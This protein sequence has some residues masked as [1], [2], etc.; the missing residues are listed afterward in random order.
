[1][2]ADG[3]NDSLVNDVDSDL[4]R[5]HFGQF[6]SSASGSAGAPAI[7]EPATALLLLF[8]IAGRECIDSLPAPYREVLIL[9][10][11]VELDTD[12]I[13]AM[14]GVSNGVVKTRL[15]RARQAFCTLLQPICQPA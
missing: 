14:L 3:N 8:A 5:T 11:I 9:R 4:S 7:P 12:A 15:H 1:M 2:V 13:A 6:A 10:D